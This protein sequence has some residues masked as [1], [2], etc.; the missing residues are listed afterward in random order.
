[1]SRIEFCKLQ[2][3]GN[4]FILIDSS[5]IRNRPG[6]TFYKNFARQYCSRKLSVGADGVLVIG[7]SNKALFEMRIFNSDGSEAEMCGNGARSAGLWAFLVKKRKNITFDTKAGIIEAQVNGT[8]R[9]FSVRVK[10]SLPFGLKMDLP[11]KV[12]GRKIRTNFVNTGVPHAVIFVQG[13]EK[14]DVDS[15][16]RAVRFD[17]KFEPAGTN[18]D[19]VEINGKDSVR[20]RTYERGVEAETLA[21]GTGSLASAII[22]WLKLNPEIRQ[23]KRISVSVI[24]RSKDILKV[25]FSVAAPGSGTDKT[26]KIDNVWLEGKADLVYRGEIYPSPQGMPDKSR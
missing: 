9:R 10:S 19:F 22:S 3:S 26:G 17:K 16:G 25:T 12:L 20:I 7:P 8:G 11:V 13:L 4:D 23:K 15:I 21:C 5:R 1:M 18:V 24:T 2:A 14:I 6:S